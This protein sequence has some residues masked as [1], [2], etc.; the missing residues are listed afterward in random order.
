MKID[1]LLGDGLCLY[2]IF[3]YQYNTYNFV[4][5]YVVLFDNQRKTYPY[6]KII[7]MNAPVDYFKYV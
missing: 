1:N 3:P 2:I 6:S 7:V 5:I 4:A